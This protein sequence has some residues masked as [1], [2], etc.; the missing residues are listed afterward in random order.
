MP[1][2][3]GRSIPLSLGRRIMDDF[4]YAGMQMPLVTIQKD[5]NLAEVVAA[6]QEA[7]PKPS[8][9]SIFTKAYGKVVASRPEMRRAFMAFPRPRIF[10]FSATTADIAVET[11]VGA[12]EIL[13][14]VPVPNP[15][16]TPLPEIDR[17]LTTCKE[18]PFELMPRFRHSL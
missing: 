10:E 18:K 3:L 12:E 4:L 6:R 2:T 9:C 15:E 5:M 11:R 1:E 14:F 7:Q 16:S 8:W 13:V 17:I